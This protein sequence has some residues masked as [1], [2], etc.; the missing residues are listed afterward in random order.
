L[1]TRGNAIK[2]QMESLMP[3]L[4]KI[5]KTERIEEMVFIYVWL[6]DI[7]ALPNTNSYFLDMVFSLNRDKMTIF[8]GTK[9]VL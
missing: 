1:E 9:H 8:T 6:S 3:D 7:K 2:V 5:T 4:S